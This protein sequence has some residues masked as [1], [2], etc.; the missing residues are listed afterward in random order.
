MRGFNEKLFGDKLVAGQLPTQL[1][2]IGSQEVIDAVP[3]EFTVNT[4]IAG[5]SGVAKF[6]LPLVSSLPLN[7]VVNWGDA[8]SDT[9]TTFNQAQTLHTYASGGTYTISITGSISG[10]RFNDG[11]DKLKMLNVISW[12]SL[13]ISVDS[14]FYGCVNFTCSA[15]DAPTIT[16]LSL[17]RY[18]RDCF[19]FNG[20]IGNWDVSNVTNM[21]ST[22]QSATAF[23]QSIGSWNTSAVTDMRFMFNAATAFNQNIG[24]WNVSNVTAFT[25]FMQDKTAAN[26]SA[27][28]LD[29]IYNGWS[30]RTVQPNLGITFGTIKYTAASVAGRLILT[31]APNNWTITDGGI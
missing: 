23:N 12:G 24:S 4:S 18:F 2:L 16:T 25:G 9:I 14:G 13:N 5:S 22:F 30:S 31:S 10:W 21:L 27:A 1:G 3:F 6:Q 7:A 29:A 8:T 11:G 17:L 15:T 28:N 26:Y 19:N 20:A